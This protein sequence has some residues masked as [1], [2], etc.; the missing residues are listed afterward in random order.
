[1]PSGSIPVKMM[2][3][4][5]V[6]SLALSVKGLLGAKSGKSEKV[7]ESLRKSEKSEKSEKSGEIWHPK[8]GE[9]CRWKYN[10]VKHCL[11]LVWYLLL[12]KNELVWSGVS[13]IVHIYT[14][15]TEFRVGYQ[16]RFFNR[17]FCSLVPYPNFSVESVESVYRVYKIY[18]L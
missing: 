9:L 18:R 6:R 17:F 3:Q 11:K 15:Y 13:I 5:K 10:D 8:D 16:A 4:S 12:A 1:M 2:H 14:F 7:W